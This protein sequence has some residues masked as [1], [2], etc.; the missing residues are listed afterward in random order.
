MKHIITLLV[1]CKITYSPIFLLIKFII[2]YLTLYFYLLYDLYD[3]YNNNSNNNNRRIKENYYS[4]RFVNIILT[5]ISKNISN[6]FNYQNMII[7]IKD[8]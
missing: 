4:T 2:F 5:F 1:P 3:L 7:E 6:Y 8:N